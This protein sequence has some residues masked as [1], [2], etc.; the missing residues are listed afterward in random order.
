MKHLYSLIVLVCLTGSGKSQINSYFNNNPCWEVKSMCQIDNQCYKV[1]NYNYIINGDSII[2]P[3]QYKKVFS[4]GYG[5]NQYGAMGP[6]PVGNLCNSP[7]PFTQ[8]LTL[9]FF[10]RSAGKKMYFHNL[11][12]SSPD[13]LLYD[14]NL[15]VGDTLPA[16]YNNTSLNIIKVIAID[17]INTFNGWMKRFQLNGNTVSTHL[18]EG[19]GHYQGLIEPIY[20]NVMSC[21]WTL[22][23][24]SQNNS[25]YYPSSGP[26]CLLSTGIKEISK[27]LNPII[28][29][30]P[31]EGKYQILLPEFSTNSKI[32]IYNSI[33]QLVRSFVPQSETIELDIQKEK[34]GVYFLKYISNGETKSVKLI[35]E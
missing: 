35:K 22:Q 7:A 32:E 27:P 29:P 21:G 16:S 8:S 12:I 1:T 25:A 3:Y 26:S 23:C 31:S 34:A 15:K 20:P 5:N 33:G 19:M 2:G 24:Y 13:T 4:K 28:Y 30:N 17:S 10:I 14:F 9:A 18:I 11:G 6:P